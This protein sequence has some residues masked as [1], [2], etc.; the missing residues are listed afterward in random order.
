M[1]DKVSP[2][3]IMSN[4]IAR[5]YAVVRLRGCS[6]ICPGDGNT[7]ALAPV[8]DLL[9]TT[10]Y[11]PADDLALSG[12]GERAFKAL[13][14]ARWKAF[15]NRAKPEPAVLKV[16]AETLQAVDAHWWDLPERAVVPGAVPERI[17]AHVRTMTTVLVGR[18]IPCRKPARRPRATLNSAMEP[19]P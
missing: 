8:S 18:Q 10:P 1:A 7:P 4:R 6:A 5:A 11:L 9:S 15:D 16:V 12:S 14:S 19:M 3:Q 13:T 2:S 17:D